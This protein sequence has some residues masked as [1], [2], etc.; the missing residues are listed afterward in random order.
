MEL[1][2][3]ASDLPGPLALVDQEDPD[4]VVTDIRVKVRGVPLPGLSGRWQ[5]VRVTIRPQGEVRERPNRTHC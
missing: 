1:A 4:V 5:G 3:V 2:G